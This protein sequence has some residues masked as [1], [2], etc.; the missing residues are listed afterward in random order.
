M[1]KSLKVRSLTPEER[2]ALEAGRQSSEGFSVR[3]SQII[4]AS[5]DAQKPPEI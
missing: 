4:L 3:R 5:A 1:P 2:T